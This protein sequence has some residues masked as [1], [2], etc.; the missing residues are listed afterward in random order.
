MIALLIA[1]L[2]SVDCAAWE[3]DCV[4]IVVIAMHDRDLGSVGCAD[5]ASD[6]VGVADDCV[7]DRDRSQA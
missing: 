7:A 1:I 4:G 3:S 6:C 2:G 5:W